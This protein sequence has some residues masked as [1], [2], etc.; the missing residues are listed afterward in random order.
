MKISIW[1]LE[2]IF[3]KTPDSVCV[4]K[5]STK[6]P[7]INGVA[8]FYQTD[9]GVIVRTEVS[10]LPNTTGECKF[11]IFAYH[12]HNGNK[13]TGNDDDLFADAD[14]HYNPNNCPH[15][16]HSGDLPPLFSANGEAISV[17]L[18]DKFTA[19]EIKGRTVIIHAS[20]DD[21]TTQP[22]GNA[23]EKIAC[24]IIF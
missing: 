23:G 11:D 17:F 18:T 4:I 10:G 6:Y 15:P 1:D 3:Q 2:G 16:A 22:A 14:G 5:G 8:L 21:F 19:E 13:C 20:V 24:G 7:N 12:I 9:K